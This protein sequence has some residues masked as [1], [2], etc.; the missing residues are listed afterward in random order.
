M[1]NQPAG[2]R[3]AIRVAV[4]D[5]GINP[6]HSHV[7]GVEGGIQFLVNRDRY[8]ECNDDF[9]DRLGH[10]TAVAAAIR[11]IAERAA[12]YAVKVFD[13]KLATFPS[14]L[15]A[16]MEWAADNHMQII[17]LSL[18]L[19]RDWP[20]VRNACRKAVEAGICVVAAFD[21]ERGI[22]WPAEY[23]GVFAVRAGEAARNEWFFYKDNKFCACGFPREL[24]GPVR[25]SNMHG[26][27]FASAHFTAFLAL[28]LEQNPHWGCREV[29]QHLQNE[30]ERV[31]CHD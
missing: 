31:S 26:H 6:Y 8:L 16:A 30:R 12:L 19:K 3:P 11:G 1:S 25:L 4:V 23:P 10:G 20:D 18:G 7:A 13:E 14:V 21:E 28:L 15:A 22:L 9:R 5:S 24:Q 2:G 27:S 17:N 29:W